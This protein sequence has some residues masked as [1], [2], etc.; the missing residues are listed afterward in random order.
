MPRSCE[1]VL[2]E[3]RGLFGVSPNF[4][5]YEWADEYSTEKRIAGY[6]KLVALLTEA[7]A[8]LANVDPACADC[9]KPMS[10]HDDECPDRECPRFTPQH[11]RT[12]RRNER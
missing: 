8:A 6:E 7:D 5:R 2:R 11:E 10:V 1:Q 9:G 12:D 4:V 3:L